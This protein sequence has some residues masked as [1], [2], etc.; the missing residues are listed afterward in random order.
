ML[1]VT[2]GCMGIM[3]D[4]SLYYAEGYLSRVFIWVLW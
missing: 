2:N 1:I 3:K 4:L